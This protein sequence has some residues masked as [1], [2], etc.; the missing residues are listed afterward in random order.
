[1]FKY[2]PDY[3]TSF[4]GFWWVVRNLRFWRKP[5]STGGQGS[6]IVQSSACIKHVWQV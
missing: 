3:I 1:M 2:S 5:K 4:P 6:L